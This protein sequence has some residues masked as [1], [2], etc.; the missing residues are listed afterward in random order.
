MGE[1]RLV[2]APSGGA[3]SSV[4]I[5]R[6][7]Y[8]VDD[9]RRRICR[10]EGVRVNLIIRPRLPSCRIRIGTTNNAGTNEDAKYD[11]S[12]SSQV[13]LQKLACDLNPFNRREWTVEPSL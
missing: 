6:D 2:H 3:V 4:R 5:R 9:G 12:T 13:P 8:R 1:S 11:F 10:L 7:R